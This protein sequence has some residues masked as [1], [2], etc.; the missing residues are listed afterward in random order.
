MKPYD[1]IIIGGGSAGYAA[2]RTALE[3]GLKVAV[4]E[5][6]KQVGGLCILR[7]CMPTKAILESSHRLMAIK[8]AREF[9]IHLPGPAKAD[10]AAIMR[11]K[12]SLIAD[13]AGYRAAQLNAGKFDFFRAHA[14]FID[15]NSIRLKP[16]A[17]FEQKVPETLRA[18]YFII[19]TGSEINIMD[20]PGLQEVGFLTSDDVLNR[21]T[22]FD[23]LVVL[24]GGPIAIE[25]ADYYLH[26]GVKVTVVQRSPH[27]LKG[28]DD[29]VAEVVE[30]AFRAHGGKLF[31]GTRL[32]KLRRHGSRKEVFFEQEGKLQ[33]VRAHEV[34][35]A[36]G[37]RPA[38]SRLHLDR[39]GIQLD[40]RYV[41]TNRGMRTNKKHIYAVGDVAG[42]YE[43]VH[44]AILQG[45]T[46][47]RNIIRD[48]KSGKKKGSKRAG[49]PKASKMDY[50]LK[51]EIVFCHPEVASVGITEKEAAQQKRKIMVASYPFDDHGKSMI[52][53]A[54]R[55]FVKIIADPKSGEI[56]GAQIVGPHASDMIHEFV[57][58][59]HYRSTVQDFV[60]IPHYHPTLA[61]I[62][63][64][65][66]EELAEKIT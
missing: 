5:G 43:I 27:I 52:M 62:V 4:V 35:Y 42:P 16:L 7:G 3:G 56:L 32:M 46:A 1:V 8:E 23:S 9:G 37:R 12:N 55:G 36:L 39:A 60:N 30:S 59:M 57:V 28:Q 18:K 65:P 26:L 10:W 29:D 31:T 17:R 20:I 44:L 40:G 11:R 19:A 14:E 53:G 2:A 54:T 50:R 41:G 33:S 49:K 22:P 6:G 66:A 64:Y 34:L 48:L 13:F 25:L 15:E 24:G 38:T 61:E 21:S 63:T 47:A 51:M 58:A 45:E